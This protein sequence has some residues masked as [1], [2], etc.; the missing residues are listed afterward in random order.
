MLPILIITAIIIFL[1]IYMIKPNKK[2]ER[3]RFFSGYK[4]AHRGL[5]DNQGEYPENSL[6]AFKKAKDSGYGVELDVQ[7]TADKKVVVFHDGDLK[8]M[9]GLDKKLYTLTYEELCGLTLLNTGERIPLFNEVL[10]LLGDTPIICEI[11]MHSSYR[12]LEICKQV[13]EILENYSPKLCVESFNPLAI[14]YFRK[15]NPEIVRGILSKNFS[16][17]RRELG[18]FITFALK[19]LLLNFLAKPDFIAF[20]HNDKKCFTFRICKKLYRP[21]TVAWTVR[22]KDEKA[23]ADFDTEIFEGVFT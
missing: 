5:F 14:R 4:Y 21:L 8:R 3:T 11:K 10:E 15:N 17:E 12:D 6:S 9:C 22:G 16:E 2:R 20:R 19:N 13:S 7:I 1:Y 23:P 18:L